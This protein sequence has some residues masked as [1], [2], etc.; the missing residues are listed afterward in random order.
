MNDDQRVIAVNSSDMRQT[1]RQSHDFIF[2]SQ[3]YTSTEE[4]IIS[5]LCSRENVINIDDLSLDNAVNVVPNAY[6]FETDVL[7]TIFNTS[8]KNLYSLLHSA[9]K[10]LMKTHTTI[11]TDGKTFEHENLF[12]R[13]VYDANGL[14]MVPSQA[15][16]DRLFL[17]KSG[18][19][20]IDQRAFLDV[21]SNQH[22]MRLFRIL[23]RFKGNAKLF[24]IE[25]K[26]LKTLFGVYDD[27][28]N[29][30]KKSYTTTSI[31]LSKIIVP[32]LEVLSS[33]NVMNHKIKFLKD[34]DNPSSPAG[35]KK[36]MKGNKVHAIEFLYEWFEESASFEKAFSYTK[37]EA[38]NRIQELMK[39]KLSRQLS[40]EELHE[41]KHCFE[42]HE[43]F[44]YVNKFQMEI[45]QRE[46]E[47]LEN[48]SSDED[49]F[50]FDFMEEGN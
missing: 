6:L 21:K 40:I 11:G 49:E 15:F 8:A 9:T 42:V 1:F 28:G 18:F 29:V 39:T 32:A 47:K 26:K 43:K 22:A 23:S 3:N 48:K 4:V 2:Q 44:E 41:I 20:V 7:T 17:S 10:N 34:P 50:S 36:I 46:K 24:P 37:K 33:S 25:I 19:A 27:K 45:E 38:Y 35:L 14:F 31:F 12:T 30:L 13:C 5:L 16:Y